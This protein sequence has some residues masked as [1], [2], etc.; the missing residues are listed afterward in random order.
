MVSDTATWHQCPKC[1]VELK[2]YGEQNS[3]KCLEF[4][5]KRATL[6]KE[7]RRLMDSLESMGDFPDKQTIAEY[8]ANKKQ[9]IDLDDQWFSKNRNGEKQP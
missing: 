5:I 4:N 8:E 3:H 2:T 6:V 1:G 9:I 7:R